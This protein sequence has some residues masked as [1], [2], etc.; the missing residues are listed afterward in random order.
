MR[1][2]RKTAFLYFKFNEK[3]ESD[4]DNQVKIAVH[5]TGIH[6]G[7]LDYPKNVGVPKTPAD[8]S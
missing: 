7:L 3:I 8:E 6:R 2:A 1:K 4:T 5:L